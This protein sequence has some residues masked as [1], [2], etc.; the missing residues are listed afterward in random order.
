M[1]RREKQSDEKVRRDSRD[2]KPQQRQSRGGEGRGGA[3]SNAM[4]GDL[5]PRSVVHC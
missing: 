2:L 3:E 5:D 4:E 1:E